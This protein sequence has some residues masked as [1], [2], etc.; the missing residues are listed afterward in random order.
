MEH[1]GS[2]TRTRRF[3]HSVLREALEQAVEWG[4][5]TRNICDTATPPKLVQEEMKTLDAAQACIFLATAKADRLHAM[6]V[7][8]LTTGMRQGELF[9]LK[10]NDID[11]ASR[12]LSVRRTITLNQQIK[13]PKTKKGLRT[14]DLPAMAIDALQEHR[15]QRLAAGLAGSEWVFSDSR[16]GLL[17]RQNLIRRSFTPILIKAQLPTIRFHDLRHTAC[18]LM[19]GAGINPRVVSETLGHASVAFTLDVYGHVMPGMGRE[20]ADRMG[21]L[22]T[23]KAS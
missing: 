4:M 16:G 14:I 2:S 20:A 21:S 6:Y 17:R 11:L 1:A 22:L 10:W 19:L 5:V 9:T 12:K 23:V 3:V 8:A 7:L 15:K 18:V 13:K